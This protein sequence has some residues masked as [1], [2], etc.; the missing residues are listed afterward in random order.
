MSGI[1]G[2]IAQLET[3]KAAIE[4]ALGALHDIGGAETG[5]G[6]PVT[7]SARNTTAKNRRSEGQ[8]ARWAAKKSAE[9]VP[10]TAPA[11]AA[12][13]GE[14]TTEGRKRLAEAMKKRWAVKRTAAQA[15]KATRKKAA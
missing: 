15:K 12:R 6:T 7:P 5:N 14:M 4:K 8:K 11:E 3:Q 2:V 1:A 10:A 13:K 9:A